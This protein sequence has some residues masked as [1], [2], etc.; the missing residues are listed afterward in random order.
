[1]NKEET[2]KKWTEEGFVTCYTAGYDE[3]HILNVKKFGESKNELRV[4]GSMTQ[5]A[6]VKAFT[7]FSEKKMLNRSL[8]TTFIKRISDFKKNAA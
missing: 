2:N 4:T 3:Y 5:A 6:A 7:K 8:L 1:M